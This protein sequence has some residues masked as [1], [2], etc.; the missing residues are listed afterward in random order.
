MYVSAIGSIDGS[1]IPHDLQQRYAKLNKKRKWKRI[2]EAEGVDDL[3]KYLMSGFKNL[4]IQQEPEILNEQNNKTYSTPLS[5]DIPIKVAY[6]VLQRVCD[7]ELDELEEIK[8]IK[9]LLRRKLFQSTSE[10]Y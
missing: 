1:Y 10:C 9:E 7:E 8:L 4:P 3:E 6:T 2:L 5:A